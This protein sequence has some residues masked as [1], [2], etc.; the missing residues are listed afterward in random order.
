VERSNFRLSVTPGSAEALV[1]WGGKTK[2]H[3][4][5]YFLSNISAN[6]YQN[7]S[8]FVEV[9]ASQSSVIFLRHSVV[10]LIVLYCVDVM[11]MC[12]CVYDCIYC[13]MSLT[14]SCFT[15]LLTVVQC[16]HTCSIYHIA[17]IDVMA[18]HSCF[19]SWNYRVISKTLNNRYRYILLPTVSVCW[20]VTFE[21]SDL[22]RAHLPWYCLCQIWRSL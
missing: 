15:F 7:R 4:A 14:K 12:C 2:N 19:H 17:V 13:C 16:M 18:G 10:L 5:V 11:S 22:W 21:F 6:N 3:L 9:I 1:R 20:T 8:M